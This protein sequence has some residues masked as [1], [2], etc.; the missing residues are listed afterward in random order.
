MMDS[1]R[2]FL[3]GPRLIIVV[4]VCALP[5]V[6]L[7]TSSLTGVFNGSYGTINGEDVTELDIQIASNITVDRYTNLYGE[8]FNFDEM[9]DEFRNESIKQE[10]IVQKSLLSSARSFGLI[11][12]TNTKNAKKSIV[13]NP[14]FQIDGIFD[15]D[16]YEAQVKSN[17]FTKEDYIEF[18]SSMMASEIFRDAIFRS[19][20]VTESEIFELANLL[21]KT[22]NFD[23]I[24][25][26]F[27]ALKKEIINTEE[28][29]VEFYKANEILFYTD[30]KRNFKYIVFNQDKYKENVAMPDE[31]L[32]S[33]YKSYLSK[34]E[35]SDQ[36]RFAHI[37]IEKS[38]HDS[39]ETALKIISD[40][41]NRIDLGESF[42]ELA[43]KFSE[44]FVTKDIGGD[45]EYFEK[46]IFPEE[47][48]GAIKG[49]AVNESSDIIE[50]DDTFHI[51]KV[52]EV[53]KQEPLSE[54]EVKE[55]L[56]VELIENESFA[57][58]NDDLD[59]IDDLI[60]ANATIDEISENFSIKS[61]ESELYSFNDFNFDINDNQIKEYIFSADL[62]S[63]EIN[64][65]EVN[66]GF[67]VLSLSS[68]V[69]PEL[70]SYDDVYNDLNEKLSEFKA[71]EKIRLINSEINGIVD[72][73]ERSDFISSYPFITTDSFI[74]VK[75][76]SSLLPT[77]VLKDIFENKVNETLNI[78]TSNQD[79][80]IVDINDFNE[81]DSSELNEIM[82][83]YKIYADEVYFSKMA[84]IINDDLFNKANVNLSIFN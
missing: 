51:L 46:D 32:E 60:F 48:D 41:K 77:E 42:D 49:L 76:Y 73:V 25:I 5:F 16:I 23:F 44:D 82:D 24:K 8:D 83:Q 50:L 10:L 9:S 67:I 65:I 71:I 31:Y 55:N 72:K 37:M 54:E 40:V 58:M 20:F 68:V 36:I 64:L 52:T 47:F 18:V 69:E 70:Q 21:E 74:D 17:G 56:K 19:S 2:N 81:P 75:R 15:E 28:E 34:F 35:N 38:N 79:I 11:N 27:N 4:L 43:S 6:F 57:L 7:G 30:E 66:D 78:K 39:N 45:L 84:Q 80:Y 22:S 62:S 14:Q 33:E 59:K 61:E 3:S 1:L 26:D 29:L 12:E 13:R 63:N 53:I